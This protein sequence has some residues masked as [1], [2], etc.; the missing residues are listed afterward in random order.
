MSIETILVNI[1]IIIIAIV[2]IGMLSYFVLSTK[3]ENVVKEVEPE[4]NQDLED[5]GEEIMVIEVEFKGYQGIFTY[6]VVQQDVYKGQYVLV[7]TRDG[8]RCAE[9]V[10]NTKKVK[11]SQ[12]KVPPFL[13]ENIICIADEVDLE[14]YN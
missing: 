2:S 3:T 11:Q 14:Y 4:V 10:S 1:T 5:D 6:G 12:L 7:L 13:L 9:V 8:I